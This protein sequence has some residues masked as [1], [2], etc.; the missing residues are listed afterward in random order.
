[1]VGII[2]HHEVLNLSGVVIAFAAAVLTHMFQFHDRISDVLGIR[3]RFDRQHILVPLALRVGSVITKD[4]EAKIERHRDE[5]MRAV[6]YKYATSRGDNLPVDKHDIEH[7]LNAWSWFWVLVEA[8]AY[9]GVGAIIAWCLGSHDLAGDLAIIS[10]ALFL[11]AFLQCRRLARYA[12]P[13][14]GS[15]ANDPTAAYNVKRQFD[16]L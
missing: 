10:A 7:A 5:L 14:I 16:A 1:M 4:K 6:F 13:Q 8:V 9:F 11:I 3:R 12:Q 15:I 2:P